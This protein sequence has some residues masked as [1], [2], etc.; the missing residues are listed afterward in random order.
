MKFR[1]YI[2]EASA[3]KQWKNWAYKIRR[4]DSGYF[5]VNKELKKYFW[6][7]K[8]QDPHENR[9][10]FKNIPHDVVL[11]VWPNFDKIKDAHSDWEGPYIEEDSKG[12][13]SILVP[14][15]NL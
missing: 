6:G 7:D 9:Y 5:E 4:M 10:V 8:D 1:E 3:K 12:N 11:K 13:V 14:G 15:M 2:T